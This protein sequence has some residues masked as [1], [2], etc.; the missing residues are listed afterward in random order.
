MSFVEPSKQVK[1][2]GS[3]S[4]SKTERAGSIPAT[5]ASDIV[6]LGPHPDR[7]QKTLADLA[8]SQPWPRRK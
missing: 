4:V 3:R 6:R 2:Y 7:K 8:A 5:C 1:D